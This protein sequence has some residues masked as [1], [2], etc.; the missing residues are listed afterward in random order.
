MRT[1]LLLTVSRSIQGRVPAQGRCLPE[2]G[3]EGLSRG[4]ASGGGGVSQ[5][6]MGHTRPTREQNHRQV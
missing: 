6:V 4:G 1:A 3:G 2:G 5:H